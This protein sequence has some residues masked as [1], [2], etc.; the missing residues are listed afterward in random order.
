[1][2]KDN[3]EEQKVIFCTECGDKLDNFCFTDS[4]SDVDAVKK[5]MEG[6]KREG[7]YKGDMCSR[8]FIADDKNF[9]QLPSIPKDDEEDV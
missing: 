3:D 9:D 6:C 2:K 8:M 4:A 1:M 5:H 7:R